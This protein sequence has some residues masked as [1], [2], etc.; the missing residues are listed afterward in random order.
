MKLLSNKSI[1]NITLALRKV[2]PQMKGEE[3]LLGQVFPFI[4]STCRQLS[5]GLTSPY[6]NVL[7][8][9]SVNLCHSKQE[10]GPEVC[11]TCIW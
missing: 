4:I 3:D 6:S 9:Y 11:L 8:D 10:G 1:I 5:S 7:G 2:N